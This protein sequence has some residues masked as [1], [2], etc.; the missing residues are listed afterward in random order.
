LEAARFLRING[1]VIINQHV[2]TFSFRLE[3]AKEIAE[4]N[5]LR[6]DPEKATVDTL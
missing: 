3:L 5:R 1:P 2:F 4:A 6:N